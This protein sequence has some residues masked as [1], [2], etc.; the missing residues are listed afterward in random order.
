MIRSARPRR[1]GNCCA[2]FHVAAY[3]QIADSVRP[4]NVAGRFVRRAQNVRLWIKL[5]RGVPHS[6]ASVPWRGDARP[7]MPSG[8]H[9]ARLSVYMKAVVYDRY[10]PPDVLGI[11]VVGRPAPRDDELLVRVRATTVNRFD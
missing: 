3:S 2:T 1:S 7:T 5:R 11:E 4:R 6:R 9:R 10:G 8:A